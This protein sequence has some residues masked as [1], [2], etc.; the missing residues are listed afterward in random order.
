MSE[1]S[2]KEYQQ[3]ARKYK[4][5]ERDYRA[6]SQMYEQIERLRT[7]NEA[8][9]EL[10]NFY[11]RL[12]LKNIPGII[13]MLDLDLRF[14]L[15]NDQTVQELGYSVMNELVGMPF[16]EVFSPLFPESWIHSMTAECADVI[17]DQREHS[18]ED[19]L[20][21]NDGRERIYQ[22][23]IDPAQKDGD[24]C[25]GV[26]IVA[27]DIS[28][29]VKTRIEALQAS[30]AKGDFLSNMSHE[31]RTPLN[32]IIAMTAIA[33]GADN[34]ETKEYSLQKID[35]ASKHLLS[36]INDVLDMSKIEA[37]KF[38]LSLVEFEFDKLVQKVLTVNTYRVEEKHQSFSVAIDPSI[39]PVLFGDDQ[40]LAQVIT[41]LLSNAVKFTPEEGSIKL[42]ARVAAYDEDTQ[43][44]ELEFTVSDSG[45]GISLE[46]Q[47]Q[48]FTSF[49]QA[50]SGISRSFG[51]TG[52]GLV[53]SKNIVEMMG[54]RIWVESE[55]GAGSTF[56]FTVKLR[57]VD[58]KAGG[59]GSSGVDGSGAGS[60]SAAEAGAG[61]GGAEAG[62]GAGAG[63]ATDAGA[64]AVAGVGANSSVS[65]SERTYAGT[66]ILLAEDIDINR[67][68]VLTI[69]EPTLLTIDC[70]ENGAEALEMFER[71]PQR[72]RMIF[73]DMQMPQMDGLEATRR[74]RSLEHP[75]AQEVP[76]IA[77]TANVFREDVERCLAAGMN[78]HIGK[79]INLDEVFETLSRYLGA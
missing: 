47:A 13:F 54:G 61:A 33:Q 52:L 71:D 38:D 41:N 56:S 19:D 53:I 18:R 68:I 55:V 20:R 59:A 64:S 25:Q 65:A 1:D 23:T 60:G 67:E 44:Y 4:K 15:G 37:Q 28:E 6:L 63:D 34:P 26:I 76:I 32:A 29:L 51:G 69:L 27:V 36:V 12:L 7:S 14:V 75:Y 58:A 78:N 48:L 3:L 16:A 31:M 10:F 9:K 57:A 62:N 66:T 49:Q 50:D 21:L 17:A 11:N 77:M 8:A 74:I 40:R 70:A 5:L 79:P 39:P 46:Q 72:Y 73:M 45:I 24:A 30:R 2:A 35:E 42:T 43:N 22:V